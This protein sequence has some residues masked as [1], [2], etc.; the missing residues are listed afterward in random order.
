MAALETEQDAA[1][2][3]SIERAEATGAPIISDG[4]QRSSSFATY[5]IT[6]TLAGTGLAENLGPGGQFF[7]IFA[8]KKIS[9]TNVKRM[10]VAL[11]PPEPKRS[12][13]CLCTLP[14]FGS[15]AC[16]DRRARCVLQHGIHRV[17]ELGTCRLAAVS[18]TSTV[19]A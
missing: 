14:L 9:S 7:A 8:S 1:V 10:C 5:P 17:T 15:C 4:E 16:P 3:D 11:S 2:R 13:G 12:H 19:A 6:D 18:R